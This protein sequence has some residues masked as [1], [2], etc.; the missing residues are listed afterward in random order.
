M[1]DQFMAIFDG[2]EEAYGY[3]KIERTA[4][5]GKAQGKA[6]ITRE[7]RTKA[8]WE[9]H[10]SGKGNGLGSFPSTG[11]TC[12]NGGASTSTNTLSTTSC[13]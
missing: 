3:F 2:L 4:A 7:P 5:N 11:I 9:S 13:S 10:L 12:A 8:L 6:G 1:S